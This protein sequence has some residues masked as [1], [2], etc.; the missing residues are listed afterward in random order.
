MTSHSDAVASLSWRDETTFA[1]SSYDSEIHVTQLAQASD[2]TWAAARLRTLIGHEEDVH[3]AEWAPN[4]WL[5][6]SCADS[7]V[8]LWGLQQVCR[9]ARCSARAETVVGVEA[10]CR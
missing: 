10:P 2:G 1:S 4:R 7:S 6:A 3:L 9:P 8:K 5:L